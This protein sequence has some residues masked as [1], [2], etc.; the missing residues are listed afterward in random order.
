MATIT[1][2]EPLSEGGTRLGTMAV[3]LLFGHIG[4]AE[5]VRDFVDS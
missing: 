1:K 3:L 4:R 2:N 5:K